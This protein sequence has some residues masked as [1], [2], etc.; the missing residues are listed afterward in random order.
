MIL[1]KG[2]S[3]RGIL[4][5]VIYKE[6]VEEILN[7]KVLTEDEVNRIK[8]LVCKR[9]GLDRIPSNSEILN[10][11]SPDLREKFLKI[12]RVKFDK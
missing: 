1:I 4:L 9:Y 5:E 3:M 11:I 6:I 7:R 2:N 8:A 12:L 10:S